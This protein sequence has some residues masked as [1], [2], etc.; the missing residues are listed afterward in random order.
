MVTNV[1]PRVLVSYLCA[2]GRVGPPSAP[3]MVQTD[4]TTAGED[5]Y[6][7]STPPRTDVARVAVLLLL[8]MSWTA[9]SAQPTTTAV[10]AGVLA[11]TPAPRLGV[12]LPGLERGAEAFGRSTEPVGVYPARGPRADAARRGARTGLLVGAAVGVLVTAAA[13]VSDVSYGGGAS[14]EYICAWH[15][16]AA[17]SVLLT[18]GTTVAGAAIGAASASGRRPSNPRPGGE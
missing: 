10:H 4:Y 7:R 11:V 13:F 1:T 15:V 16:A 18:A 14:C 8:L 5:A 17:G 2:S 6:P 3:G 9:A 12:D